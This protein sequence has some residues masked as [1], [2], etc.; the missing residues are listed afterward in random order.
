MARKKIINFVLDMKAAIGAGGAAGSAAAAAN[1]KLAVAAVT[2][3]VKSP[4]WRVYMEQFVSKGD[5]NQPDEEQLMRLLA[6]DG[7]ESDEALTRNRAY[8][9]ANG[10]CGEGTITKFD[11]LVKSIDRDIETDCEPQP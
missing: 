4:A 5:N 6:T 2:G 9:V 10:V 7:T 3:G 1:A 8:L 11:Q